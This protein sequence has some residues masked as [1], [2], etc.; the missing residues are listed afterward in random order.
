MLE[1]FTPDARNIVI[2]A[3]QHARRLGHRYVGC[4]HLLLAAVSTGQP[5]SVVLREHGIS[6]DLVEEQIV[7]QIGLG[8]GIPPAGLDQEALASIGIDLDAV[9]ARVEASFGPGSLACAGPMRFTPRARKCLQ[10]SVREAQA[11]RDPEIGVLHIV[12]TLVG[13]SDGMAPAI[14]S[15][16]GE[17][18]PSLSAAV[19]NRY[20][21]AS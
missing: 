3:Q 16:L 21:Q 17:S 7:R 11:R 2:N 20:R 19:L 6:P 12:L 4:E 15:A 8:R 10:I 9:R 5:A 18:G 1:R 13:M 14:L